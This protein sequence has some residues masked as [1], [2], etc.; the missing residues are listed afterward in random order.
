MPHPGKTTIST[1]L[2]I[3]AHL[4]GPECSPEELEWAVD[5]PAGKQL[6]EW[7]ASQADTEGQID[8]G[9]IV[10]NEQQPKGGSALNLRASL[11]PVALYQD[12]LQM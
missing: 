7:I 5:I 2:E 4:G 8:R 6:L 10:G 11:S 1:V 12:E 9:Q 3:L